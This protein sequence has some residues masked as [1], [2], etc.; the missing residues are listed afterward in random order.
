MG[1]FRLWKREKEEHGSREL[2]QKESPI[3][4][5]WGTSNEPAVNQDLNPYLQPTAFQQSTNKEA[6]L[7]ISKLDL[8]NARL[9]NLSKRLENIEAHLTQQQMPPQQQRRW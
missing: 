3:S 1:L 7:I 2:Q 5:A 9:E 4:P 8:I 6:D